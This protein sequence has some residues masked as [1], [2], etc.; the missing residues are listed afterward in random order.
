[1]QARVRRIEARNV[2]W[3]LL[4]KR[5]IPAVVADIDVREFRKIRH[6]LQTAMQLVRGNVE[7]DERWSRGTPV[8]D[9]RQ[10]VGRHVEERQVRKPVERR[11]RAVEL[12]RAQGQRLQPRAVLEIGHGA[13]Q[14]VHVRIQ[15]K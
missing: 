5:G 14:V 1:M 2:R 11:K 3:K 8:V 6:P 7:R 9:S 4:G 15:L 13:C 12:V 10:Q